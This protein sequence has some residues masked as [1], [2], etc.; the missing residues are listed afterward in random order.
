MSS[1]VFC[2]KKSPLDL[3][4]A[5]VESS[6]C[7][8][9]YDAPCI[10]ACP[11]GIN[12]PSF[13]KKI[14]TG[15]LLGSAKDIL[16]ENIMGGTCARVCPVETLCEQA[17]VR[18][19]AEDKPVAI[20]ALQR[21]ATDWLFEKKINP[22]KRAKNSEKKIAVVGAGPAGLS[23]A[24][25]LAV[26]G[27][28]VIIFESKEK[29]GGLNEYGLAAYKV[30]NNFVQKEIDFILQIGGIEIKYNHALG[31]KIFLK[32]LQSQFDAVFLGMGLAGT[33]SLD[34]PNED[35]PGVI[36]AVDYIADLRQATD[37]SKLKVGK[38][39][40]VVGGG[41]TAIDICVQSKILGAEDVTLVY[42]RGPDDMGATWAE[43]ELAQKSGVLIKHWL[44]PSEV[45]VANG[46]VS[47]IEL[48]RTQKKSSG[49]LIGT[50]EKIRLNCDVVFKAIGQRLNLKKLGDIPEFL[51]IEKGKIVVDQKRRT[52][53]PKIFAGGD[54]INGGHLTVTSVQDGK[55]AAQSIQSMLTGKN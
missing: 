35:A 1:A 9:C 12:I 18:N 27:H 46:K 33:N 34:I 31:E 37:L 23:C 54:C 15:N 45:L 50:G 42:R 25:A 2:D 47:G 19:K 16:S 6:R 3:I 11:T 26:L 51:K 10:Q 48:E 20:G 32:D 4:T 36:D 17:C 39:I 29:A 8:F 44:K 30:V 7:Y 40:V 43:Q 14:S 38:K 49:E 55:I 22:F 24:H 28:N 53:L 52:L 21:Y 5:T 13:I 41:N